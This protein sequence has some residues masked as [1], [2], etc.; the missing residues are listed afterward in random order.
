ML[1]LD[2]ENQCAALD[3]DGT[4][5]LTNVTVGKENPNVKELYYGSRLRLSYSCFV[6]MGREKQAIYI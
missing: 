3:T 5:L 4:Q 1:L 6:V 2:M